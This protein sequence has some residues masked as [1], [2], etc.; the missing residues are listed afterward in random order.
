[1]FLFSSLML[2]GAGLENLGL[3]QYKAPWPYIALGTVAILVGVLF[4][5]MVVR[6][7]PQQGLG[8]MLDMIAISLS[9]VMLI[10]G[11]AAVFLA[12]QLGWSGGFITAGALASMVACLLRLGMIR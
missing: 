3:I 2:L 10:W 7:G 8:T 6:P 9:L 4:L 11:L 12:D 1:M 5:T